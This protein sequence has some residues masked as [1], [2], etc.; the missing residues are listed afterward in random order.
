LQKGAEYCLKYTELKEF[1]QKHPYCFTPIK[2]KQKE[3]DHRV[4]TVEK[5]PIIISNHE[6]KENRA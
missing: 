3:F 2:E 4:A 5:R 1:L 6:G